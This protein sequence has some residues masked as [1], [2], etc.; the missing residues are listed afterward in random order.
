MF[1]TMG[2]DQQEP[3]RLQ[4]EV[5]DPSV[6]DLETLLVEAIFSQD[7]LHRGVDS[8]LL[9]RGVRLDQSIWAQLYGLLAYRPNEGDG[10]SGQPIALVS[11]S[12]FGSGGFRFPATVNISQ[13]DNTILE[14]S[15]VAV[16]FTQEDWRGIVEM[17]QNEGRHFVQIG[18]SH[19]HP[20]G[21]N[22][23]S[24]QDLLL[25]TQNY[26][27]EEKP[28][29]EMISF[30]ANDEGLSIAIRQSDT[31][32][33]AK[34]DYERKLL[35]YNAKVAE[36]G[37]WLQNVY[38]NGV[39]IY[40]ENALMFLTGQEKSVTKKAAG[41]YIKAANAFLKLFQE[42]GQPLDIGSIAMNAA[43]W[44]VMQEILQREKITVLTCPWTDNSRILRQQDLY[45]H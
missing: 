37:G 4:T 23:F 32:G 2:H 7:G 39:F 27:D 29:F 16:G 13:E 20:R 21:I 22:I 41:P 31:P 43:N 1:S 30:M 5:E 6:P 34:G 26:G 45:F 44:V 15:Q 42:K 9:S 25:L 3:A 14:H 12:N 40:N 35:D 10:E 38:K 19:S 8:S 28:F 24:P 17:A 36:L 33:Y 18:R 11:S